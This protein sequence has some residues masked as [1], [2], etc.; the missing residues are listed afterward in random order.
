MRRIPLLLLALVSL[1]AF[2]GGSEMARLVH[3]AAGDELDAGSVALI[4]W[5]GLALP[6]HA[7]E[8]EAFLSLDGGRTWP[9]RITPHLDISIR[10]FEFPVPD[11]PTRDARIL[12]R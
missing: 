7:D 9:L 5:E 4:E 11:F 2:A 10:R 6:E 3:P 12:L 1:P 8:W